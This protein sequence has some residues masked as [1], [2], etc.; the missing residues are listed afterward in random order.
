VKISLTFDAALDAWELSHQ[1]ARIETPADVTEWR[2]QMEVEL[3]KLR[4]QQVWVLIDVRG[5]HVAAVMMKE[6]GRTVQWLAPNF[7]GVVRYGADEGTRNAVL[8]QS[9]VNAFAPNL[10][11]ERAAA[12]SALAALRAGRGAAARSAAQPAGAAKPGDRGSRPRRGDR[13]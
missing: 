4:G 2:R 7:L 11:D 12:V 8:L 3:R 10:Y 1:E 13:R 6:Y 5:F 9:M